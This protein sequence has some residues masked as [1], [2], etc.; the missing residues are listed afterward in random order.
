MLSALSR[1]AQRLD[2]LLADLLHYSRVGRTELAVEDTDLDDVVAEVLETLAF[3]LEEA[4]VSVR[5]P[6]PLPRVTCDRVRVAELF[7]NLISN[8]IKYNDKDDKWIEITHEQGVFRVRD[9]GIGIDPA[10][11]DKVFSIFNRLHARDAYGGG[12]GA[13]LTIAKR[14]VERHGGVI[15]VESQPGQGT[16]FSFILAERRKHPR[17]E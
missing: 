17:P 4:G 11:Y 10:H 15:W 14:I 2:R 6:E 12:T 1:L 8:A 3:S 9:N 7:R 5:M 13:G 16:T